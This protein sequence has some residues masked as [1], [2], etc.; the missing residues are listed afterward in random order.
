MIASKP[1]RVL[2]LA[3]VA[4]VVLVGVRGIVGGLAFSGGLLDGSHGTEPAAAGG[5]TP[6]VVESVLDGD[7]VEVTITWPQTVRVRFLGISA[8]EIPHPGMSGE[9]YGY[10][11]SKHLK[12]LLLPGTVRCAARVA[13]VWVCERR[14]AGS[15]ATRFA[16]P[17]HPPILRPVGIFGPSIHDPVVTGWRRRAPG[18]QSVDQF[19]CADRADEGRGLAAFFHDRDQGAPVGGHDRGD[20]QHGVVGCDHR[21]RD[22]LAREEV[23]DHLLVQGF[24]DPVGEGLV[25]HP[26]ERRI[27]LDVGRDQQP[28]D[29]G[30]GKNRERVLVGVDH[31]QCRQA[32][33]G[34]QARRVGRGRVHPDRGIR[35]REVLGLHIPEATA[36]SRPAPR[37]A[38]LPVVCREVWSASS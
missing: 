24:P 38:R 34:E 7:T 37:D 1:V 12:K 15:G 18:Q 21:E 32:P 22:S 4:L 8:P 14:I 11:S 3:I 28:Q 19:G 26:R 5:R 2:S 31:D 29:L 30:P 16:S 25:Q 27:V 10:R 6:A 13:Y 17:T 36:L 33:L 23:G 9:C 35:L 20:L